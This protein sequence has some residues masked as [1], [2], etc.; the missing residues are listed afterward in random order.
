[1]IV[2]SREYDSGEHCFHGEKFIRIGELCTDE[3]RKQALIEYGKKFLKGTSEKNGN[4][5][6]KMG[7]K[8]VL[9]SA[10]LELWSRI[11]IDVQI[12]ICKYKYEHYEIVREDLHK[13]RRNILIH[14]AMRCSDEKVKHRL[15]EGRA[16]VVDG[17]QTIIGQ[18]MLGKIW[19]ELRDKEV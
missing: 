12:E 15:W 4:V 5:I 19:M 18:N 7:R 16:V 14:P 2:E 1:V 11:S 10:E 13:S 8:F 9:T 6:K 17:Q 3:Q